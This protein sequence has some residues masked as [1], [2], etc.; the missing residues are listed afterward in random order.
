[1]LNQIKL[2]I[3]FLFTDE[4]VP[5]GFETTDGFNSH[6]DGQV[7]EDCVSQRQFK[8]AEIA[9]AVLGTE[10]SKNRA[11]IE[12]LI[13]KSLVSTPYEKKVTDA[14]MEQEIEMEEIEMK[15]ENSAGVDEQN[16]TI[17]AK[18]YKVSCDKRSVTGLDNFTVQV[19]NA[20]QVLYTKDRHSEVRQKELLTFLPVSKL[21]YYKK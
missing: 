9:D 5:S 3:P 8:M 10:V 7:A 13:S 4:T 11:G 19:L 15:Q 20:S 1:M 18:T 14:V 2:L 21:L 17:S 16:S 12:A 6:C